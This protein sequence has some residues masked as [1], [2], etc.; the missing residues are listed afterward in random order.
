M[1]KTIDLTGRRFNRLLVLGF[2]RKQKSGSGVATV[3]RCLCDCGTETEATTSQ[4]RNGGKKSCGCLRGQSHGLSSTKL[5]AVWRNI[6]ARCKNPGHP[7]FKDYGGR[8]I[9]VC[10]EWRD[11]FQAFADW[12]YKNGYDEALTLDRIDND[13]GYTP[14]NCRW[15]SRKAQIRNRRNTIRIEGKTL[16]EWAEISG[17][18]YSLVHSRFS[19]GL[20]LPEIIAKGRAKR[21]RVTPA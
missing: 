11:S 16:S 3:W 12:A 10:A 1:N 21:R 8:G 15:A 18:S 20:P 13:G 19:R 17:L 2:S 6:K 9:S 7:A 14:S 4:L 5:H